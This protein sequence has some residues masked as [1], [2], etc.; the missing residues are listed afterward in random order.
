MKLLKMLRTAVLAVLLFLTMNI[1]LSEQVQARQESLASS[2]IRFHVRANSDSEADQKLKMQ[3]KDA[4]VAYMEE[5]LKDSEN[6]NESAEIIQDNMDGILQ[7]AMKVIH[8]NGYDYDISGYMAEEYFPLRVYGDVA[9]PPGEYTAFRIDIGDACGKNW[10]CV[11]YPPL[12]FVDITHGVVPEDTK[13]ELKNVIGEEEYACTDTYSL[14]FKYLKF[15][16]KW[17]E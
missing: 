14:E 3:V 17:V 9:L 6:V 11:L 4:V 12:C 2:L 8:E 5:L 7:T 15:L 1:I 13:E 16:N 10:W